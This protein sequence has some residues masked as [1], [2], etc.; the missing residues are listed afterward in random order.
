M[1][2]LNADQAE[3]AIELQEVTS[4]RKLGLKWS[5]SLDS[6]SFQV[7]PIDGFPFQ[8]SKSKIDKVTKRTVQQNPKY[9]TP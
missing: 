7:K 4:T 6:F 3:E 1:G 9:S 2:L 8:P 5:Q